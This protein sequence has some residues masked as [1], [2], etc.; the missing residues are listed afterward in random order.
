MR[1]D[2]RHVLPSLLLWL[3][4]A[5]A[6][7]AQAGPPYQTDDP[8]PVPYQ[9]FE[10]YAFSL[11]DTTQN[12]GTS[13]SAPSYEV[14]YGAA[15]NLQLHLVVPVVNNFAPGSS[16]TH[17]IG[18]IEFG[19][20]YKL[21]DETAHR[22]EIG[23]F[24]FIEFPSGD[25]LSRP[26]RRQDLVPA[27]RSGSR[28]ASAKNG[29]ATSAAAKPFVP[30]DGFQNFPFAGLLAQRKLGEKLVLGLELYGHGAQ[31]PMPGGIDRATLADFGGYYS[32]TSHFQLLFAAGHSIF[33]AP[34][35]YTYLAAYWTWGK[36]DDKATPKLFRSAIR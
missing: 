15:K 4:A 35:T 21:F 26:R 7:R 14:N 24:P 19:A 30:A 27:F 10:M 22:P 1:V 6:M 13:W 17:G 25:A 31:T 34:E 33:W 9:H 36:D 20:K 16:A 2:F 8:D 28:R 3:L 29:A 12:A 11:S 5:Q 18:D 23:V 32:F